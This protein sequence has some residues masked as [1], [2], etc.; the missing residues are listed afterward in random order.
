MTRIPCV[1]T[2][3]FR[4]PLSSRRHHTRFVSEGRQ[5][6]RNDV[7]L[8]WRQKPSFVVCVVYVVGTWTSRVVP[9]TWQRDTFHWFVAHAYRAC[10]WLL[11]ISFAGCGGIV[12]I[13]VIFSASTSTD[14][15]RLSMLKLCKFRCLSDGVHG[16]IGLV[17]LI[18]CVYSLVP[19]CQRQ[20][21]YLRK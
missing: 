19:Y 15:A 18:L 16:S 1:F 9:S 7:S 4:S 13:N 17:F 21:F 2:P 5:R 6:R 12:L 8:K 11:N 14:K 3:V 10:I 20:Q